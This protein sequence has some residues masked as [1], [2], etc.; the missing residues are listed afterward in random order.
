MKLFE[1]LLENVCCEYQLGKYIRQQTTKSAVAGFHQNT[2]KSQ[3]VE[4]PPFDV[5]LSLSHFFVC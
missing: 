5:F 3:W 1:Q 4:P 2:H